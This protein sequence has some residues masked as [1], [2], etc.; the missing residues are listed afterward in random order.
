MQ[1]DPFI[2]NGVFEIED[3][4]DWTVYVDTRVEA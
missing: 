2:Q 3:C 1:G 4:A